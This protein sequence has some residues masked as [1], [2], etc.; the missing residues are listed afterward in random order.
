[1]TSAVDDFLFLMVGGMGDKETGYGSGD[2]SSGVKIPHFLV[3]YMEK[4]RHHRDTIC[5]VLKTGRD[6]HSNIYSYLSLKISS[7]PA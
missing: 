2:F 6:Q 3:S 1:V 5:Q 4:Q 7:T